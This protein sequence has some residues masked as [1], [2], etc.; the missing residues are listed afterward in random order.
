MS[1]GASSGTTHARI[2]S[3]PLSPRLYFLPISAYLPE[4]DV[5]EIVSTMT[6]S[7][8]SVQSIEVSTSVRDTSVNGIKIRNGD[9]IGFL[10]GKLVSSQQTVIETFIQTLKLAD[11]QDGEILTIYTGKDMTE[12]DLESME[13]DLRHTFSELELDIVDGGQPLYPIVASLE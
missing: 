4:G 2:S 8:G 7:L 3:P 1:I 11:A 9:G 13:S 10:D 6:E 5:D 12:D